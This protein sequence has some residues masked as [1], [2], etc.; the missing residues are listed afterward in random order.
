MPDVSSVVYQP[1]AA[2][3]S[4]VPPQAAASAE[5]A[6]LVGVFLA[7]HGRRWDDLVGKLTLSDTIS[8]I[9]RARCLK[10]TGSPARDPKDVQHPP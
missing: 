3:L 7:A 8:G 5:D 1:D 9:I 2:P 10:F 4:L 6:H